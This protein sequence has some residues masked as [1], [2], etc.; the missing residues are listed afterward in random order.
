MRLV[1]CNGTLF[2]LKVSSS[3]QCGLLCLN[4]NTATDELYSD[5]VCSGFEY[6][7]ENKNCVLGTIDESLEASETTKTVMLKYVEPW[8]IPVTKSKYNI[9]LIGFQMIIFC[10]LLCITNLIIAF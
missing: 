8:L 1:F 5:D 6:N 10:I 2:L 3:E 9:Y 7:A 4:S